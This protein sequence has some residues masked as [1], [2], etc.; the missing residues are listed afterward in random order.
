MSAEQYIIRR[1][2]LTVDEY[3]RMAEEGILAPDARVELINGVILDMA[4][5][6]NRHMG[7]VNHLTDL[8]THATRSFAIVQVQGPLRLGQY[9]APQPDLLLLRRRAD[10][11]RNGAHVTDTLLA[12]EVSDT[13]FRYDRRVKVGLYAE[14][15]VPELWLFELA[16]HRLHTFSDPR[17]GE[18]Q[19]IA[20]HDEPGEVT[21]AAHPCSIDLSGV[22]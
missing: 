22:L 12:I 1:H 11:Y 4:P 7:V 3:Y 2:R 6:G 18:Y 14:H 16:A 17:D 9:S 21:L 19:S 20:V 5:I 10:F 8:L 15:G 13:T